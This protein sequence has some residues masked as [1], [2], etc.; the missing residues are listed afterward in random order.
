ML[1]QTLVGLAILSSCA[2]ALAGD[3]EVRLQLKFKEGETL[4]IEEVS[5]MTQD[6]TLIEAQEGIASKSKTTTIMRVDVKLGRL[7]VAQLSN[8]EKDQ[9]FRVFLGISSTSPNQV[10]VLKD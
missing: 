10:R 5:T 3:G 1:R 8:A 9:E 6:I 4:W 2:A 7:K